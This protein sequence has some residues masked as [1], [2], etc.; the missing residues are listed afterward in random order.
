M[1]TNKSVINKFNYS[2]HIQQDT[3]VY[4]FMVNSDE[5]TKTKSF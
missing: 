3:L 5:Q 1:A 4:W 2:T